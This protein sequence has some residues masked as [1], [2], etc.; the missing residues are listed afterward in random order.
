MP[1]LPRLA[2]AGVAQHI[3]QR[4]NNRQICFSSEEDFI[5]YS[6]WLS[7]Y[8]KKFKVHIH[9]WVF[10]TNHVH[11]LATSTTNNGISQMMQAIGRRYVRYFN[12]TYRRSGTLWE[13]RFKSCLI[14]SSEYLLTC[15]RYIELNPVRANMVGHP[16]DYKWS[17]YRFHAQQD[18][19][20]S[21]NYWRPH[22]LYI[23]LGKTQKQRSENYQSLF[24]GHIDE[25]E[26]QHIRQ[27]TQ[28]N[29]ALGNDRFKQQI[30]ELTGRRVAPLKRGPKAKK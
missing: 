7:E 28:Q 26:I 9:A 3:I 2:I 21:T 15:Q 10:M 25:T 14:N 11:L 23:Q 24:K 30:E 16:A 12:D 6:H 19:N 22:P 18:E 20:L 4:G 8:A 17:I 29:M 27:T 5:T 1:R 13:G